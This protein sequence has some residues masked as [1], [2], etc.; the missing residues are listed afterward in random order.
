M[1]GESGCCHTGHRAFVCRAHRRCRVQGRSV[2]GTWPQY[3]GYMVAKGASPKLAR[4]EW[5]ARALMFAWQSACRAGRVRN[6]RRAVKKIDSQL[7]AVP[8]QAC[9]YDAV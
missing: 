6:A 9:E 2:H 5:L 7:T 4:F 8:K 3:P 1:E